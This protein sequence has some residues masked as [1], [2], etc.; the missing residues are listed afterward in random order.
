MLARVRGG[1]R[2]KWVLLHDYLPPFYFQAAEIA[3]IDMIVPVNEPVVTDSTV[4]LAWY[5]ELIEI[6]FPATYA[7]MRRPYRI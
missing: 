1:Y 5:G 4:T 3:Y 7:E 2:A 6:W